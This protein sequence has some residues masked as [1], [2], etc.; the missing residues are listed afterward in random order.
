M[1]RRRLTW[2]A[3]IVLLVAAAAAIPLA[4]PTLPD[5]ADPTPTAKVSPAVPPRN[6]RRESRFFGV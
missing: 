3:V 2:T 1:T 4:L 5:R 6:C